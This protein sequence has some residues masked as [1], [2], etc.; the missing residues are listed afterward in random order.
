VAVF[1]AGR[2]GTNKPCPFLN[3]TLAQILGFAQLTQFGTDL[4]ALRLHQ[5]DSAAKGYDGF[6][7]AWKVMKKFLR[8]ARAQ[9]SSYALSSVLRFDWF[10]YMRHGTCVNRRYDELAI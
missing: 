10:R 8:G 5:L 1:N 9:S 7:I 3:V 6:K 2:I 4:H